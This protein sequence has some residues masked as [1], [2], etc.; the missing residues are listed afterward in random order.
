MRLFEAIVDANHRAV[1][2]NCVHRCFRSIGCNHLADYFSK[3][4]E[5][6][7]GLWSNPRLGVRIL[8]EVW[9]TSVASMNHG[10]MS[11]ELK[12]TGRP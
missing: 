1:D 10:F 7:F 4:K 5:I 6:L 2:R 9:E 3:E 8:S 12:T 11:K